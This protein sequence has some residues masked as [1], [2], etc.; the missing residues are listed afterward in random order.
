[1]KRRHYSI[2]HHKESEDFL[3]N[4]GVIIREQVTED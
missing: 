2:M 3:L 1:M 4:I